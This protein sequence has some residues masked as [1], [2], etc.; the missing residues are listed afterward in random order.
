MDEVV[1]HE[2]CLPGLYWEHL[3]PFLELQLGHTGLRARVSTVRDE[4]PAVRASH[5]AHRAVLGGG[6]VE[7]CPG[8]EEGVSIEAYGRG[9]RGVG[10]VARM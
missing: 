9:R 4:A 2:H 8:K 3:C 10:G 7:S 6:V 5:D 1:V